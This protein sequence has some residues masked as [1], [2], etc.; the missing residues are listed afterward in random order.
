MPSQDGSTLTTTDDPIVEMLVREAE[1]TV[2]ACLR[3]LFVFFYVYEY[4]ADLLIP[5]G[6]CFECNALEVVSAAYHDSILV[7]LVG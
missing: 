6:V 2:V 1:S 7:I 4:L 5:E 3:I